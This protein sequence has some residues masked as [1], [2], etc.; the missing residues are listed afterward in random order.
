VARWTLLGL[1]DL[2]TSEPNRITAVPLIGPAGAML[3]TEP[4]Y[5]GSSD[6]ARRRHAPYRTALLRFLW[7][8]PPAPC[9]VP[10]RITAVPLIG[11]AVLEL[12]WNSW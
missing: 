6:R 4:H 9:S 12:N 8:G 3:R 1:S 10:N 2:C 5:C 7:S 11:S